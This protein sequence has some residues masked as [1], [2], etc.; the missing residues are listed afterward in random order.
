MLMEYPFFGSYGHKNFGFFFFSFFFAFELTNFFCCTAKEEQE[1]ETYFEKLR[2][3]GYG[4]LKNVLIWEMKTKDM[5]AFGLFSNVKVL[6]SLK[7]L[8]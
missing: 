3:C 2:A 8:K 4:F 1:I 6:T 7:T 5:F